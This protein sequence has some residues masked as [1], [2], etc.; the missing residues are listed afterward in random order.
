MTESPKDWSF[1]SHVGED[2]READLAE[3]RSTGDVLRSQLDAAGTV[4]AHLAR[5][6]ADAKAKMEALQ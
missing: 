6:V 2:L 4:N 5:Q 3:A 1:T